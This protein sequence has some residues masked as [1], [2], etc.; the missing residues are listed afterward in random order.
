MRQEEDRRIAVVEVAHHIVVAEAAVLEEHP[1]QKQ[2]AHAHSAFQTGSKPLCII[3][4]EEYHS[5]R[6]AAVVDRKVIAVAIGS[7]A[8][9]TVVVSMVVAAG[10]T[11][12][13]EGCPELAVFGLDKAIVEG[14]DKGSEVAHDSGRATEVVHDAGRAIEAGLGEE[15]EACYSRIAT[16]DMVT[17]LP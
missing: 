11:V 10:S 12:L 4:R 9:S 7:A 8:V 5:V 14:R 13:A 17:V 6:K 15:V 2:S 16:E 3:K 1:I